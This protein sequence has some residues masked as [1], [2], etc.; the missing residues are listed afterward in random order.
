MTTSLRVDVNLFV[1]HAFAVLV[2]V[3]AKDSLPHPS[4]MGDLSSSHA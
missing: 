1:A 3:T 2:I 4:V